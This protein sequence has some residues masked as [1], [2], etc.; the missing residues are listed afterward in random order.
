VTVVKEKKN[1]KSFFQVDLSVSGKSE[2]KKKK[3][4]KK[5]AQV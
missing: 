4:K 3:K 2:K 5:E 1:Q